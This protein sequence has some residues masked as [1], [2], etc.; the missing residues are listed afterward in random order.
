MPDEFIRIIC[1][2]CQE[3]LD[4]GVL[5][6]LNYYKLIENKSDFIVQITQCHNCSFVFQ[7]PRP[8]KKLLAHYY[9]TESFSVAYERGTQKIPQS[10]WNRF[11]RVEQFWNDSKSVPNGKI[12]D[13]GTHTG[14]FLAF[15]KERNYDCMG[16]EISQNAA[17]LGK[18]WYNVEIRNGDISDI[19]KIFKKG[20]ISFITAFH[21]LEHLPDFDLFFNRVNY[22][23]KKGGI[24]NIE[25]PDLS[26][27]NE[28]YLN[29]FYIEHISYFTLETLDILLRRNHFERING[30]QIPTDYPDDQG[31]EMPSIIVLYQ[32]VG[33]NHSPLPWKLMPDKTPDILVFQQKL[34]KLKLKLVQIKKLIQK[35]HQYNEIY[36][37]G[38]GS[39]TLFLK[40]LDGLKNAVAIIDSNKNKWG[41]SM[42][43]LPIISPENAKTRIKSNDAIL[44]SSYSGEKSILKTALE[45]FPSTPIISL[46]NI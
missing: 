26:R 14:Q 31:K 19:D 22:L 35:S 33:G 39:H 46:Y 38:S 2:V 25:V 27:M 29:Y 5:F 36:I 40:G 4:Q 3:K 17:E 37:W 16:L 41:K 1:P 11:I 23:L 12:L 34:T 24:I 8:S 30:T 10:I 20:S 28:E 7:N 13:L 6:S 18:K 44:I 21:I 45:L 15:L 32:K 9:N 42:I 43:N